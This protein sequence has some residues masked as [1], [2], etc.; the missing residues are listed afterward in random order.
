M[1]EL[2]GILAKLS[3]AAN[4]IAIEASLV[5]TTELNELARVQIALEQLAAAEQELS[6]FVRDR[7][8]A[9]NRSHLN[10]L[11]LVEAS[12]RLRGKLSQRRTTHLG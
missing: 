2:L 1:S 7:Q 12:E 9:T 5:T 11:Q 8:S 6:Q 4:L 3:K 10:A